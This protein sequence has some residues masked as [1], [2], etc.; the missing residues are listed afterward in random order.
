MRRLWIRREGP[1]SGEND[2]SSGKSMPL[3]HMR[4]TP[5]RRS[6]GEEEA[7]VLERE[8]GGAGG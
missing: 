1:C 4:G 5:Q 7:E 3:P 6:P 2:P 8:L